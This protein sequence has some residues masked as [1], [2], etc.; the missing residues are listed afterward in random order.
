MDAATVQRINEPWQDADRRATVLVTPQVI[1]ECKT[2]VISGT[3]AKEQLAP[4]ASNIKI[5]QFIANKYAIR[6][7]TEKSI[8]N[9][10]VLSAPF[11]Y[12]AWGAPKTGRFGCMYLNRGDHLEFVEVMTPTSFTATT[13]ISM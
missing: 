10:F 6:I 9:V 7:I 13:Y 2:K 8:L 5:N 11:S 3:N 4:F 12:T 1:E